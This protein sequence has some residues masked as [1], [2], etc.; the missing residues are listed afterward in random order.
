MLFLPALKNL[1]KKIKA[2]PQLN[3]SI[4]TGRVS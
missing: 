4:V 1:R 3:F 2:S